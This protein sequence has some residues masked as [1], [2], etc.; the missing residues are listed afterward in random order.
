MALVGIE[1]DDPR[2]RLE[3]ATALRNAARVR[4]SRAFRAE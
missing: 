4:K 1:A 2:G 3:R